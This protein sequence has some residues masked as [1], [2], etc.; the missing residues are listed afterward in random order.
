LA[1]FLTLCKLL[2]GAC[3]CSSKRE[4]KFCDAICSK[5]LQYIYDSF[6][7]NTSLATRME[8]LGLE[9]ISTLRQ[10]T[11]SEAPRS[12]KASPP[13]GSSVQLRVLSF[14]GTF[15]DPPFEKPPLAVPGRRVPRAGA[16]AALGAGLGAGC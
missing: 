9:P 11:D 8:Q 10:N 6:T 2:A 15:E 13:M 7:D 5:L 14:A 16:P 3:N 1:A 12:Q 4:R